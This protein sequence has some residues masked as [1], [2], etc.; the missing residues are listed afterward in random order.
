[1]QN[2]S[3]PRVGMNLLR[4][5]PSAKVPQ[6][7]GEGRLLRGRCVQSER[8]PERRAGHGVEGRARRPARLPAQPERDPEPV[9]LTT[10]SPLLHTGITSERSNVG[11]NIKSK[12]SECSSTCLLFRPAFTVA[13][14]WS[15]LKNVTK[16][17]NFPQTLCKNI[18]VILRF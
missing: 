16:Q 4:P 2:P 12:W 8:V 14:Y 15:F 1:M 5:S 11:P 7:D 3:N 13:F 9:L 17:N 10:G 18:Y 6:P